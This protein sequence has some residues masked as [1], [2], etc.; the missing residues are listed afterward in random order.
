MFCQ[1]MLDACCFTMMFE[2]ILLDDPFKGLILADLGAC[3]FNFRIYLETAA[4]L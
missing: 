2:C 3:Q 1:C 4:E